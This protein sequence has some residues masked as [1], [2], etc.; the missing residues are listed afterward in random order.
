MLVHCCNIMCHCQSQTRQVSRI[1]RESHGFWQFLKPRL[2]AGRHNA[3][4]YCKDVPQISTI[5]AH[6]CTDVNGSR[7]KL[8]AL[9]KIITLIETCK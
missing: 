3:H 1:T 2:T 6:D 5:V 8:T 9:V 7:T 4:G